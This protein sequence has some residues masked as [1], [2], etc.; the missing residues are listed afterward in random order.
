MAG[1]TN[2]EELVYDNIRKLSKRGI[3]KPITGEELLVA[4]FG[5]NSMDLIRLFTRISETLQMELMDFDDIELAELKT[6]GQ[7]V[8]LFNKQLETFSHDNK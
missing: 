6:A 1:M 2:V 3:G 4:D 8:T 5:L 7:L